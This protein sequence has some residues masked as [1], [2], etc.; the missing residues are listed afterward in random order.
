[1]V[2]LKPKVDTHAHVVLILQHNAAFLIVDVQLVQNVGILMINRAGELVSGQIHYRMLYLHH[3]TTGHRVPY[4][5]Y[6]L[7]PFL[8]GQPV[9]D[10]V[11]T[12]VV[13]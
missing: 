10:T 13:V 11:K 7:E 1:M 12:I 5:H 8:F 2:L 4:R 3:L 6:Y 9:A